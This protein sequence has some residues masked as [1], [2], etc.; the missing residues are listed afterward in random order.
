MPD[1]I[2]I[3][4]GNQPTLAGRYENSIARNGFDTFPGRFPKRIRI[5]GSIAMGLNYDTID[6][7][8]ATRSTCR[9]IEAKHHD[10]GATFPTTEQSWVYAEGQGL[11]NELSRYKRVI[12]LYQYPIGLEIRTNSLRLVPF[13]T[14]ALQAANF[15]YMLNGFVEVYYGP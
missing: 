11:W 13:Y 9:L 5:P 14:G 8:G 7:D 15:T 4:A 10:V 3:G 1:Q 6:V 12:D 2:P